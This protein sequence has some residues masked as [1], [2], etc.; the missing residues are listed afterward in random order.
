MENVTL[1]IVLH[2]LRSLSAQAANFLNQR[3]WYK[4]P[5]R[6][7]SSLAA[8]E[9]IMEACGAERLQVIFVSTTQIVHIQNVLQA[10]NCYGQVVR[11]LNDL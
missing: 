4:V 11:M 3:N 1:K 10:N 6:L 5:H 9:S 2:L 7:F 8:N